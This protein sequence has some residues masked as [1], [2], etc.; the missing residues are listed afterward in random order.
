MM[1]AAIPETVER[2]ARVCVDAGIHVH[3]Q[4][5]PGF[6]E[7]I[8]SRAFCL[9]LDSRAMTFECEKPVL[10]RYKQWHIPGQKIDL[11]VG[12]CVLVE[13]KSVAKLRK[14]HVNQVISYL[15][16]TDLRLGLIMNFNTR[17]L[18]DGLKRVVL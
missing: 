5:G 15:K 11:I 12:G 16:T 4:L 17:V 8:Y 7:V 9:E 2:V 1:H 6:R 10:V 13:L 14:I 18:R 3:R